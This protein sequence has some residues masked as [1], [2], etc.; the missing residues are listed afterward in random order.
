MSLALDMMSSLEQVKKPEA[1]V[2][3]HLKNTLKN[4][5]QIVTLFAIF[6]VVVVLFF[7]NSIALCHNLT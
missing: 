4:Q 5:K 6:F 2:C 7:D 3:Y 1:L